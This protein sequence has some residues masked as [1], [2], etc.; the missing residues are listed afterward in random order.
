MPRNPAETNS[1][2]ALETIGLAPED[3]RRLPPREFR[4][5]LTRLARLR[6]WEETLAVLDLVGDDGYVSTLDRRVGALAALGRH[7]EALEAQRHRIELKETVSARIELVPLLAAAGRPDE[8]FEMARRMVI[9][10]PA[11]PQT[12]SVLGELCLE[13]G[14]LAEAQAA[15]LR[16]EELA[17]NSRFP[18]LG[19]ARIALAQGDSVGAAAYTVRAY[20][21]ETPEYA[22]SI[23]QLRTLHALFVAVRDD[24]RAAEVAERLYTLEAA[25]LA[26]LEE[27]LKTT[28]PAE[29]TRRK[30]TETPP[31]APLPTPQPLPVTPVH[32][33]A[34]ERAH[35]TALAE[36]LFGFPS[37]LANQA[38]VL[39]SVLAGKDVLAVL[40]TGS[41]KSLCYQLPAFVELGPDGTARA[42][43]AG[44]QPLTLVISPLIAL[45]QDQ[46]KGLPDL[47]RRHAV[48]LTSAKSPGEMSA[49]LDEIEQGHYRLVFVAPERLRNRSFVALLRRR[50]VRRLVVDEAHCI[51]VW[52]HNFRPDYLHIAQVLADLGAPQVVL[53]TATA[54]TLVRADIEQ[55]IFRRLDGA[56]AR[57]LVL[58]AADSYR[59]NLHLNALR[60]KS[61]GVKDLTL[62][63]LCAAMAGNGI[64]YARSRQTCED[65]AG[66]LRAEG[67]NADFYHAGL[68]A[69]EREQ[70]Q[71]AFMQGETRILVATVAF[72]MGIDKPD[73]RFILHHSLPGSLE[74]YY[75]EAGR[76]GRDGQPSFCVLLHTTSDKATLT[77]IAGNGKIEIGFLRELYKALKQHAASGSFVLVPAADIINAL[78]I[79]DDTTLY[80]GLSVLEEAG[81][82]ERHYDAPRSV[83][84]YRK[85]ATGDTEF[86]AF[87]EKVA[88]P[89]H[90]AVARPYADLCARA[91]IEPVALEAR[92]LAWRDQ[93]WIDYAG[94]ERDLLV[95]LLPAPADGTQR[96]E[97]IL[98]RMDAVRAQQVSEIAAYAAG[99][100]CRHGYLSAYLGGPGRKKCP[101]CD[102]C[103]AGG[104]PD[105][106]DLLP[107]RE[108]QQLT[109]LQT[110]E[111]R[112]LGV[113][114]LVYVL[115][116][117][118]R[119]NG[120][121]AA[122][123]FFGALKY[124]TEKQVEDLVAATQQEGLIKTITYSHGGSGLALSVTGSARVRK[125][126]AESN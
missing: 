123:P 42:T 9:E 69:A 117:N 113:K 43:F 82:I 115:R 47:I 14:N 13:Y 29:R 8:A 22:L 21:S 110:L 99:K 93:G 38:E 74:S 97:A 116:G 68:A 10:Y 84:L 50:G 53:L 56:R 35:L 24:N 121:L 63:A 51:S 126:A 57:S 111:N 41:G 92:L 34:D 5:A 87:A 80:V 118:T 32:V 7:A 39:S 81:I 20:T 124:L 109:L 120:N 77:K 49:A 59:A 65:L 45:M 108:E 104:L 91:E 106:S 62:A 64:I 40:P 101:S 89:M 58:L 12:W 46:L 114:T 27:L 18:A 61:Q 1:N 25:D 85:A 75:Q 60:V 107:P 73:I 95:T 72:G 11:S 96:I 16:Y 119:V 2:P 19:L 52:G 6:A 102:N 88:L 94:G 100:R 17:P 76:A 48:N 105:L 30:R 125:A 31:P 26:E 70:R 86:A 33:S 79:K 98:S 83:R 55:Q 54:P 66:M 103:G 112:S 15:F 71:N 67:Q 3:V 36:Q 4:K 78:A 90:A 37:L 44:G 28:A 122:N 23:D